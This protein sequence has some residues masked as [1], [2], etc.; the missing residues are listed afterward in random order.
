MRRFI[1]PVLFLTL[2]VVSTA[3]ALD[4]TDRTSV[5]TDAPFSTGEAAGISLLTDA[6]V[7][8]GNPD[9][10]FA[11]QR[12][13][14]RAEFM[15][16]AY[17]LNTDAFVDNDTTPRS[18]TCFPD[19]PKDVWFNLYVCAGKDKKILTG[20]ADSLFHPERGISYAEAVT[21]LGRLFKYPTNSAAGDEW[22][23][24]YMRTAQARGTLLP[25]N[26]SNHRPLT[27]GQM[28]RL[29]A[30]F[31]AESYGE[32]VQY[33][34]AEKGTVM[35]SSMSSSLSSSRSSSSS[36]SVSSSSNAVFDQKPVT[37]ARS[38]ILLLDEISPVMGSV[39]VFI[40]QEPLDVTQISVNLASAVPTVE[41][42]LI[43]DENKKYLGKATIDSAVAGNTRYTAIITRGDV[44]VPKRENM[45]FYAR[46]FVKSK[47]WG[48]QSGQTV[49]ITSFVFKGFG[50]WSSTEYTRTS[51]ETFP[52][53]ETARSVLASVVNADGATD[54]LIT[55]P[56]RKL[57]SFTFEGRRS[58]GTASMQVVSAD[59]SIEATGGIEL[60][61]IIM[62]ADGTDAT[63]ACSA[64]STVIS[65]DPIPGDF[66]SLTLGPRTL[67]LYGTVS[68]PANVNNATMRIT[69]NEP[70][71]PSSAGAL[72]WFDGTQTFDWVPFEA[73][74]VRG[75]LYRL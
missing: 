22:F 27:R 59:F 33:R 38:S 10:T 50:F 18:Y 5:Y 74:V 29:A 24:P 6:G 43:Y 35:S 51:S 20:Y 23:T 56:N 65:C 69:L 13:I 3:L 47:D 71:S 7:V 25:L 68:N 62:R 14:N 75:T 57:A 40:E 60:T 44:Q 11:P 34:L 46:A 39:N 15:K 64:T 72:T 17:F 63:S 48:G 4:Y 55:G 66:G 19:V 53:Y 49:Q 28:A 54:V 61:N 45:K 36:S 31:L 37:T 2:S 67:T 58:D 41:H 8:Q 42:F 9:G 16:I 1:I 12:R 73:P 70:G 52:V 21:I 26:I 32:L 30:A